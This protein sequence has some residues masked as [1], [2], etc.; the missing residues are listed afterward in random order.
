MSN[1]W[2]PAFRTWPIFR[3]FSERPELNADRTTLEE[4]RERLRL[5]REGEEN[6]EYAL[7]LS[8]ILGTYKCIIRDVDADEEY[9]CETSE[10]FFIMD[11]HYVHCYSPDSGEYVGWFLFIPYN[12][13]VAESFADWTTGNKAFDDF[14]SSLREEIDQ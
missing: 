1:S 6:A 13:S 2:Q 4:F 10:D 14:L 9:P 3:L 8:Y 7:V 11:E 5:L 12:G